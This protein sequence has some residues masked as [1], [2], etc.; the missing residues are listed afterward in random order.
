MPGKIVCG[1]V[2]WTI[3]FACLATAAEAAVLPYRFDKV[4][5]T[6]AA[7][8]DLGL[9]ALNDSGA[10]AFAA[11]GGNGSGVYFG[12]HFGVQRVPLTPGVGYYSP[13]DINNAGQITFYGTQPPAPGQV[14]GDQ[15]VYRADPTGL[16][17]IGRAAS[18]VEETMNGGPVINNAGQVAFATYST[19][20]SQVLV[21]DGSGEPAQRAFSAASVGGPRLNNPGKAAWGASG[22]FVGQYIIYEGQTV[23]AMP[24]FGQPTTFTDPDF[25]T[26][27]PFTALHAID[28]G[29]NDRVVFS[30]RWNNLTDAFYLWENGT[31]SKVAGTNGLTGIPAINDLG[32][33]AGLVAGNGPERLA[34]FQGGVEGTLISV[35][36]A[37]DGS[38]ITGLNFSPEG[39]NNL[40]QLA[41]QATLADGRTVNVISQLPE[42]GAAGVLLLVGAATL[43]RR[44]RVGR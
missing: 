5:E 13:V 7:Y 10:A 25:G 2:G 30:A 16:V 14:I 18:A 19:I 23:A 12:N 32:V 27:G 37:F 41:F 39:F 11:S 21:G 9:P 22:Q 38:V 42:P 15:I 4:A 26:S 8:T 17:T 44:R 29:D 31:L 6:G 34:L 33:V 1:V 36:Q 28:V 3:A 43:A 20:R 40:N 35:G 24:S